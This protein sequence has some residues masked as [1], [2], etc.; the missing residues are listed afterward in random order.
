[1]DFLIQKL[2]ELVFFLQHRRGL[3]VTRKYN[4]FLGNLREDRLQIAGVSAT[5][6]ALVVKNQDRHQKAAETILANAHKLVAKSEQSTINKNAPLIGHE[7]EANRALSRVDKLMEILNEDTS[8]TEIIE[9]TY[10]VVEDSD[11]APP[12]D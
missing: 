1:M 2:T 9:A 5:T 12:A 11:D 3:G 8:D 4:N 6:H 7:V 10:T